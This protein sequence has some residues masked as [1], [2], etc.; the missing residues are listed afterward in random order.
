MMKKVLTIAAA[1]LLA[2]SAW[3]QKPKSQKEVDALMAIQNAQDPDGRIAAVENL[4]TKFADTEFKT[5]A[6]M[7]ATDAAQQKGDFEKLIIYGERTLQADPKSYPVMLMMSRA[8]AQRV[9]ENDLD[10]EERLTNA[11]KLA[12]DAGEAL[13]TAQKMNPQ[14]TDEQWA[15]A[16][17]DFEAQQHESLG[18]IANVRKKYDVAAAEYKT[19][20]ELNGDPAT[21]VRLG[22]ALNN[23]GK[24]DDAIA[25]LDK[26]I[27]AADAHPQVKQVAQNEKNRAVQAKTKK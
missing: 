3:A 22:Q 17:K 4:L 15:Q 12:K 24:Y 13:K 8:I 18:M 11:E 16:K 26:V 20:V 9:R 23:G 21:M 2:T 25:Y 14:M 7:M 19:A 10:K 27:A 1:V 5:F 6:L